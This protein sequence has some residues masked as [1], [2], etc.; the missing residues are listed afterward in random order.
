MH[1]DRDQAPSVCE[2]LPTL[3]ARCGDDVVRLTSAR[4]AA[5]GFPRSHLAIKYWI[6]YERWAL[7]ELGEA[8]VSCAPGLRELH[9]FDRS[10]A[11]FLSVTFRD[12]L[13][14]IDDCIWRLMHDD[15]R[16]GTFE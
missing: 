10:G 14:A 3:R 1:L 7:C 13:E 8:F 5:L 9:M 2:T 16:P 12:S 15:Q 6:G 4:D 11:N